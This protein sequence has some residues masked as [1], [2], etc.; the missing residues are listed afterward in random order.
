[1]LSHSSTVALWT[2]PIFLHTVQN[3]PQTLNSAD[4]WWI[5]RPLERRDVE[6]ERWHA[7]ELHYVH[8]QRTRQWDAEPH[9]H[10]YSFVWS[11]AVSDN[12]KSRTAPASLATPQTT[13]TQAK[14][15][16][17][18]TR[19]IYHLRD[20]GEIGTRLWRECFSILQIPSNMCIS[21]PVNGA[22]EWLFKMLPHSHTRIHTLLAHMM[23]LL[24]WSLFLVKTAV[25]SWPL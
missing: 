6:A 1:M 2:S 23:W 8:G 17:N 10:S 18:T 11:A 14:G 4:V 19:V 20:R 7:E 22:L 13:F 24:P 21:L 5:G 12:H 16:I 25:R 9:L 15:L 3:I